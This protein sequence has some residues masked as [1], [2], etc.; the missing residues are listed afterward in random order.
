MWERVTAVTGPGGPGSGYEVAPRLVL[1]SAHVVV[2]VG[3]SVSVFHPGRTGVFT[4]TVIWCGSPGGADDAALV[5]VDDA[6]WEPVPG[7]VKWGRSVTHRPRLDCESWGVPNL[8]QRPNRPI[9][10]VQATG[11]LNPGDR[12]VGNRYLA[13]LDGF[14][15]QGDAPWGG[16][17]G[18]ALLSDDLVIGV[19]ATEP[20]DRGHAVLEAVP[21][22][23]LLHDP[24][25]AAALATHGG[26]S[27]VRCEAVELRQLADAQAKMPSGQVVTSPAGLLPARRAVVPFHGRTDLLAELTA[28][29]SKPGLGVWLL[30]GRGGQGKTRVAH[31]FGEQLAPAG[32]ATLWLDPRA[33]AAELAVLAEVRVPLLVVLDYAEGRTTQLADVANLLAQRGDSVPVKLLLLART[34]G[35]WWTHTLPKAGD[36]VRDLAETA[37]VEALPVLDDTSQDRQDSYRAAVNAF[38]AALT[39]VPGLEDEPWAAAAARLAESTAREVD[40]PTVLAVQMTALADL[41]DS[42]A[43]TAPAAG[44]SGR[45]GP[46]D[47]LLQH[48]S[49]CWEASAED[50]GLSLAAQKDAVAATAL[51]GPTTAQE[52]ESVVERVPAV[53][54]LSRD[55]R[56]AVRA[57]LLHLYPGTEPHTFA[58]LAPDRLAER[59]IGRLLVDSTHTSVI[60]VIAAEVD[61]ADAERLLTVAT[62]AAAHAVVQPQAAEVLTSLCLRH[63]GLLVP[64]VRVAP[65]IEHPAPL[66]R[67]IKEAATSNAISTATLLRLANALPQHTHVLAETAADITR[68]IV[69]RRR[70]ALADDPALSV[71]NLAMSLNNLAVRLDALG[72]H[73]DGLAAI[74]EA[75]AAYRQLAEQRPDAYL[76]DLAMSLNN[77][78]VRL[79]A[80]GLHEDGLAAINEAVAAYRQ[81]AE[82]RPDAYLPD[83]AMSLNNLAVQLG[84]LG[85]HEDALAAIMEAVDIRRRLAE[86]RPDAYLPNLAT[87]LNNLAVQLSD[88]GRHEDGLAAINEAVAA[89]RQLAEQRPDAYLPDLA[90]SLNNLAN[91][92]GAL[93]L[94]EDG[95][96][97]INEAVAAYRQLAEQR[98]D[99]YLPDLAAS[100]NNLAVQLGAHGR[101]EDALAAIMESVDIRR[102]LAE[103]RPDAYL[104]DLAASLNNLAVQLDAHDRHEDA[105]AAINEAVA[106]YR[107]LAEQRPDAYLPDL[108][109][110][111]NNLAV[112]LAAPGRQDDALAA[113]MESVDIRRR[114][115]EQ[116]PD[117]Y[118]PN[119][120]ASLNKLAEQLGAHG[121]QEDALAAIMESVDIRRR[122]AEQR[123]DAYLPNLAAS[124]NNLAVQLGAHG[125]QEDALAAIMESVDIRRRLAEQRP[126]AY[127]PNLAASLNNLAVQLG[128]H[129]RQE[130][131]LAAIMESVDIRRRLAEQRPDAYLPDLAASL[132]NLANRLD[133]HDRHEDALAAINEAIDIR[134]RLARQRPA[135]HSNS[136]EQSLRIL[137]RLQGR[138]EQPN[139][140]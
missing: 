114:L 17:S 110:S 104:P 60:E 2:E 76:P 112:Q 23:L 77:L 84:T 25:F 120:A 133:A 122:L 113:I 118:L 89:Y 29:A 69:C 139:E 82:Q 94:H 99:A 83:L 12:I 115:A 9:D 13:R 4:G 26:S 123:P 3:A 103:Q 136:L 14:P 68:T 137:E 27:T 45:Q 72:L 130:D 79:D 39:R 132:N 18:A 63:F 102:R 70:Q 91:R 10:V 140:S 57:W 106:A 7:H 37:Q 53:A 93:G 65:R 108:A 24:A 64:A 128:A 66:L 30:H 101:H 126:D 87:S 71:A 58:G 111:L 28:W 1:T 55:R 8:V 96:A 20:A 49:K 117:A 51:L 95:L 75:V 43:P 107:Q 61:E 34:A 59:L 98:P 74:N 67:A 78:A 90:M 134:R 47:R 73:E 124:L 138:R 116:R 62:R 40:E 97:A 42:T 80:L 125:R 50:L 35:G 5:A 21:L 121:R 81:L 52:L 46:E 44:R 131:A 32:W 48:E 119:L 92:L 56:D 33:S 54:D 15:P 36:A 16:M 38:A 22:S 19:I 85:R 129:G 109:A 31:H 100:L 88:L 127:L 41:L 105:L 6:A 135:I 86:Q 11:S